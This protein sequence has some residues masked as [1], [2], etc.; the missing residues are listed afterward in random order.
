MWML[1]TTLDVMV[2]NNLPYPSQKPNLH[3]LLWTTVYP[4]LHLIRGALNFLSD[5][6]KR[7]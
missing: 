6:E 2:M 5:T 7:N 1:E 3:H 4:T